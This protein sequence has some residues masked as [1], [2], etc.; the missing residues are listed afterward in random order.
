MNINSFFQTNNQSLKI[1]QFD[2]RQINRYLF[3]KRLSLT[4]RIVVG[5]TFE[6]I[7][8]PFRKWQILNL[9]GASLLTTTINELENNRSII[10]TSS[11][12]NRKK[13]IRIYYLTTEI[14]FIFL[15]KI[16]NI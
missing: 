3:T 5:N 1:K 13:N 9:R 12:A 7:S 15:T 10:Q 4:V 8:V 14:G 16:F 2:F 11:Y 6:C